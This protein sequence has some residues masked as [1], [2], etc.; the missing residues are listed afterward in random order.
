MPAE[1]DSTTTLHCLE[2]F[3]LVLRFRLPT[4]AVIVLTSVHAQGMRYLHQS[5]IKY[6]GHL[7]SN[8]VIVDSRWSCKITDYGLRYVRSH[9][10]KIMPEVVTPGQSFSVIYFYDF[11]YDPSN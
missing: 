1:R 7:S 8:N 10:S 4:P 11:P 9:D 6:H 3:K 2:W 5:C